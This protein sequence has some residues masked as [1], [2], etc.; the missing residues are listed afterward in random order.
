MDTVMVNKRDELIM[1]LVHY[2]VTEE[3]YTPM[4][5]NGTKDEVWLENTEGPYKIIR[6]NPHYIHNVEQYNADIFKV[7]HVMKQMK[8]KTLSIRM[9]TLNIMLDMNEGIHLPKVKDIDTVEMKQIEDLETAKILD[10]FPSLPNKILKDSDGIDLI[11]NVTNGINQKN[12][13]EAKLYE[14]TFKPKKIVITSLIIFICSLLFIYTFFASKGKFDSL[15][16]YRLGGL[17]ASSVHNK[18]VW[19]LVTCAFL[20]GGFIHFFCNMYSL[21]ILGKELESYLGKIR[22]LL[23]YLGSAICGS[24]MSCSL[25]MNHPVVSVGASGAIF[26]LL[27]SMLYFGSHYRLYLGS[28]IKSQILPLILLNLMIGF[29]LPGIDN[30]AHIGGL[31]GGYL[32]TMA[33]GIEG[34]SK[35]SERINGLIALGIYVT[36]LGYLVFFR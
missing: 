3:N 24:L 20:H 22:F 8:K 19:R 25:S 27:G 1:K 14:K 29:L 2:F 10:V 13:K 11:V 12:E 30:F 21:A 28:V 15:T 9:K 18:E 6:I 33:L 17:L 7:H 32:C 35:T 16:L 5:V 23:V 31:I 36:F 4:V 26:G 34:K